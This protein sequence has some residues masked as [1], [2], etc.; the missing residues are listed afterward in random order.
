MVIFFPHH[1]Y[2][3]FPLSFPISRHKASFLVICVLDSH[4]HCLPDTHRQQPH[5]DMGAQ[6]ARVAFDGCARAAALLSLSGR[7]FIINI[8]P[9]PKVVYFSP[10]PSAWCVL[11]VRW[12]LHSSTDRSLSAAALTHTQAQNSIECSLLLHRERRFT[13]TN[14]RSV[15]IWM[16]SCMCLCFVMLTYTFCPLQRAKL[17]WCLKEI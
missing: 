5:C 4:E 14:A 12:G 17:Q 9:E 1:V 2:S 6:W 16:R 10:R 7:L 3:A 8:T 11:T 15:S 13:L